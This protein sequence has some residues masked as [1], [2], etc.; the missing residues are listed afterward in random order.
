MVPKLSGACYAVRSMYH[1]SYI[2]ILKTIY[3][4]YFYSIIKYGIIFGVSS[5]NSNKI[6]TLQKKIIRIM[7]GAQPR[8][9]CRST[10]GAQS[11]T[12]YRSLFKKIRDFTYSMSIYIFINELYFKQSKKL[13]NKFIYTQYKQQ[14]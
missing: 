13:S 12:P 6:F 8:T 7:V 5:S 10:V 9:A 4:A 1:I 14:K 2:N 3:F 11:R